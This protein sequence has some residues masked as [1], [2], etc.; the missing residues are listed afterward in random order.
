MP[1]R[2]F[3]A[4]RAST[5]SHNEAATMSMEANPVFSIVTLV[6]DH[7]EI[8]ETMLSPRIH[9][10][11]HLYAFAIK[12]MTVGYA[13]VINRHVAIVARVSCIKYSF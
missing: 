1:R 7:R 11:S 10:F 6:V 12:T 13:P 8:F 2:Y 9:E 4:F 5:V 3:C